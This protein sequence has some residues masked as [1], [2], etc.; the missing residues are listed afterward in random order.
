MTIRLARQP[1]NSPSVPG[2]T[3]YLS[4]MSWRLDKGDCRLRIWDVPPAYLC[5]RHLL[6]EH[7]EL[8][9]IWSVLTQ[10]KTGY[11]NHPETRRWRG[12]L[13]ALFHRHELLIAEMDRRGYNHRSP[14]DPALATG[15]HTQTDYVDL[16]DEQYRILRQKGCDCGKAIPNTV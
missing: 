5:R 2:G 14:I 16:P 13:A 9:A 12:L 15:S 4:V 6:G 8:H 11:V 7:R 3:D 1:G 10:E